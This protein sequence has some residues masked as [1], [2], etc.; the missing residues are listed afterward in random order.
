MSSLY[1]SRVWGDWYLGTV[2]NRQF[3]LSR[4]FFF[5]DSF[6]LANDVLIS[7]VGRNQSENV[8]LGLVLDVN[9]HLFAGKDCLDACDLQDYH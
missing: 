4:L 3:G 1:I 2:D 7:T 6:C 5:L 8:F 9:V